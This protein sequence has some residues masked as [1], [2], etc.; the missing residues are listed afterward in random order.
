MENIPNKW[1]IVMHPSHRWEMSAVFTHAHERSQLHHW[2]GGFCWPTKSGG[3][4][5]ENLKTNGAVL[6]FFPLFTF[7]L[8][9]DLRFSQILQVAW[10]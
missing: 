5:F 3:T 10:I 1:R 7:K 6:F 8:S 9:Q 2:F 4:L